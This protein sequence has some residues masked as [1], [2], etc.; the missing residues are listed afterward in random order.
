MLLLFE[1]RNVRLAISHNV[2]GLR[3]S[4]MAIL[5]GF[6][7]TIT[8]YTWFPTNEMFAL[9][10]GYVGLILVAIQFTVE[11]LIPYR[12]SLVAYKRLETQDRP[13]MVTLIS[14]LAGLAAVMAAVRT[15]QYLGLV[16]LTVEYLIGKFS[17]QIYGLWP[18]IVWGLLTWIYVWLVRMLWNMQRDA[19]LFLAFV[20]VV[21]LLVDF[22]VLVAGGSFQDIGISFSMNAVILILVMLPRTRNAFGSENTLRPTAKEHPPDQSVQ[23]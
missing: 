21:N 13:A 5:I 1:F 14:I 9:I 4:T 16:P 11:I 22:L 7:L 6:F 3:V 15:L 2:A 20:T 19:W 23:T 18:A 17:F 8:L 10:L 12:T